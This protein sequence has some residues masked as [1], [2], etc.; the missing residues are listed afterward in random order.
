MQ[1]I[2][3]LGIEGENQARRRGRMGVGGGGFRHLGFFLVYRS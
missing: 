2:N 1:N 3:E